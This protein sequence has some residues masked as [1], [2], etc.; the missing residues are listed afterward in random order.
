MLLLALFFVWEISAQAQFDGIIN[1]AK[2]KLKEQVENKIS[3]KIH[4]IKEEGIKIPKKKKAK[5]SKEEKAQA[6][7]EKKALRNNKAQSTVPRTRLTPRPAEF[8]NGMSYLHQQAASLHKQLPTTNYEPPQTIEGIF[9][10]CPELPT[11]QDMGTF[12]DAYFNFTSAIEGAINA[13]HEGLESIGRQEAAQPVSN[14]FNAKLGETIA[15]PNAQQTESFEK[16][17]KQQ[18]VSLKRMQTLSAN[19]DTV[20]MNAKSLWNTDYAPQ[21]NKLAKTYCDKGFMNAKSKQAIA[22]EKQKT[23]RKAVKKKKKN[24]QKKRKQK[25]DMQKDEQPSREESR[26]KGMP[27]E[28]KDEATELREQIINMEGEFYQR[29]LPQ[30]RQSV[31]TLMHFLKNDFLPIQRQYRE[32]AQKAG[33]AEDVSI[34]TTEGQAAQMYLG[35]ARRLLQFDDVFKE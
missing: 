34:V 11:A 23:V 28:E 4:N 25:T 3:D 19:I 35:T 13:G 18:Q 14:S 32:A 26:R 5:L 17:A 9:A 15:R 22:K 21:Y 31:T 20:M 1:A 33:K 27:R 6:K 8:A 12:S 10:L 24:S 29:Y 7:A 2:Q 30:Y 16:I